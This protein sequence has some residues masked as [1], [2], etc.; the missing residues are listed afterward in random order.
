MIQMHITGR[1]LLL[2]TY[3]LNVNAYH[4]EKLRFT[5]SPNI[6]M[7]LYGIRLCR[8]SD[9]FFSKDR[10][11]KLL[12]CIWTL[13]LT[14][15]T[16]KRPVMDLRLHLVSSLGDKNKASYDELQNFKTTCEKSY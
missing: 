9:F 8:I 16:Y 11:L 1:N 2:C 4:G 15:I 13:S 14:H 7:L 6:N 12:F 3:L 10:T 5:S